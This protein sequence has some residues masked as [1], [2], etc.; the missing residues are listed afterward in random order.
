MTAN[1]WL[2][3]QTAFVTYCIKFR[4]HAAAAF[5]NTN[6]LKEKLKRLK[7]FINEVVLQV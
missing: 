4:P 5:H 1:F 7:L 6:T 3:L 2:E